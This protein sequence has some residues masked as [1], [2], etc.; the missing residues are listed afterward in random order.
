MVMVGFSVSVVDQF[1]GKSTQVPVA[2]PTAAASG[3][4]LSHR[5][6]T[7]R[8]TAMGGAGLAWL[9]LLIIAAVALWLLFGGLAAVGSGRTGRKGGAARP[10]PDHE[11]RYLVPEGQDPATVLTALHQHGYDA[12]LEEPD[13]RRIIDVT[14]PEDKIRDREQVREVIAEAGTTLEPADRTGLPHPVR[15][16]D[17]QAA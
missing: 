11:L 5:Q 7:V 1:D 4:P 2:C 8:S 14:C 10:D 16:L 12:V 6:S 15:F 3:V 17:E 13:G 9:V